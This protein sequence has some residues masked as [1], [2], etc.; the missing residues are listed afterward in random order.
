MID[1]N[2]NC[3]I[4]DIYKMLQQREYRKL[5]Q[6]GRLTIIKS[7][8]IPKLNLVILSLPNRTKNI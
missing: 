3:K 7:L 6:V 4:V 8:I 2:Y 1:L 5:T